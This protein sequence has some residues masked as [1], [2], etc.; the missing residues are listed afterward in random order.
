MG[1]P[2]GF[3][4]RN[5][6]SGYVIHAEARCLSAILE[7]TEAP[8]F[9]L[10]THDSR[11]T[12]KDEMADGTLLWVTIATHIARHLGVLGRS[13]TITSRTVWLHVSL[14]KVVTRIWWLVP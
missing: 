13:P 14:P 10:R 11:P 7:W 3:C 5:S 1:E 4:Q 12:V 9:P 6:V 8:R 2:N